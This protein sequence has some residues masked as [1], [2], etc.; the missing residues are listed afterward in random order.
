[1]R[2]FLTVFTKSLK[3]CWKDVINLGVMVLFP[4]VIIFVLGNAL[5]GF[6]DGNH[7]LD[8]DRFRIAVVAETDSYFSQF[9]QNEE[10]SHFLEATFVDDQDEALLLLQEREA[11][12]IV[13]EDNDHALAVTLPQTAGTGT[14]IPLSIID[15]Y[16]KIG[17]AMTIA[18]MQ[19]GDLTELTSM[20]DANI[21]VSQAPL[22]TR[23]PSGMDYYA[24]TMMVMFMLFAGYN[25]LELFKKSVLSETGNRMLTTPVSKPALLG[26]LVTAATVTSFLQGLS[27]VVFTW[28]V[29]GVHWGDRIE[30]VLLTLFGLALFSNAF[31]IFLLVLFKSANS[32]NVAIQVLIFVM[33]FVSGGFGQMFAFGENVQRVVRFVPNML[34]Q[35][36]I[37]GTA[38]GGNETRMMTDLS[39]LFAYGIGLFVVAFI[40]GRRKLA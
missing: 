31:A 9:L 22:G 40:L 38:F 12:L 2:D 32:A 26:G 34:A 1:M 24:I 14:L 18:M 15:S 3:Y 37:F 5:G 21:S 7:D 30:L 33:T 23:T 10:I 35:T 19:G 20:M 29:Y 17:A 25:G 4:I 8:G 16:S 6:I 27:T 28:V 11:V 39:I 36:V 13:V